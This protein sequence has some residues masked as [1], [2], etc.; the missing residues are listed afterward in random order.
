MYVDGHL[1][2]P[3]GETHKVSA[4]PTLQFTCTSVV[5]D[6]TQCVTMDAK[7]PGDLVYIVG[8]TRNELGASEYYEHMGYVGLQVPTLEPEVSMQC[9]RA[10]NQAIKEE[11]VASCHGVYR[12]G[13]GIHLAMVAMGRNLG[14][15]IDLSQVPRTDAEQNHVVLY[16]ESPGR[17]IVTIDPKDRS[18]F[19]SVMNKLPR[20]CIG[21]VSEGPDLV[22]HGLKG[23]SLIRVPV[24]ALKAAWKRPFGGLI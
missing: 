14:M 1:T 24:S 9:Y 5:E 18:S 15:T 21:T 16:S 7:F 20:A 3:Y 2:G 4:L 22:I 12:G 17:F 23:E 11:L 13:L 19:E 6:L 8:G 10:L